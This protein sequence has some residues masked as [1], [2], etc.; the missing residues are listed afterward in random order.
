MMLI[1]ALIALATFSTA[2]TAAL[3]V[4]HQTEKRKRSTYAIKDS[5]MPVLEA[6]DRADAIVKNAAE[7]ARASLLAAEREGLS[8]VEK[9]KQT[10][11][12]L[13]EQYVRGTDKIVDENRK[14]LEEKSMEIAN[15][16][17]TSLKALED[18]GKQ[19]VL[20]KEKEIQ[21]RINQYF[22]TIESSLKGYTD[23][24]KRRTQEVQVPFDQIR[25]ELTQKI[26]GTEKLYNDYIKNVEEKVNASLTTNQNALEETKKAI[27]AKFQESQTGYTE[28]LA[29]S[30]ASLS[31]G[32]EKGRG[33]LES[34][35]NSIEAQDLEAQKSYSDYVSGLKTQVEQ[36][37][38][39]NQKDMDDMREKLRAKISQ[40]E[41][42]YANF[43]KSLED[44]MVLDFNK[45]QQ[46]LDGK[47]DEFFG[48][49]QE[50]LGKFLKELETRTQ[51][52]V[53]QEI[54]SAKKLIEEYKQQRLEVVD[55]N[56]I[57]ILEKTL[58]ITLGKKLTLSDQ[59][60]LIYEA[61]E[62]AK[63]ENFFA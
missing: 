50:M 22:T 44:N 3:L 43:L 25:T 49:A 8:L 35:K 56:L 31:E 2:L 1:N 42:L 34:L 52:Q 45:K 4:I 28:F 7:K 21:E 39:Q 10:Q 48:K 14:R 30:Q 55:E 41:D 59:T 17:S 57:A 5:D 12:Q 29:E 9:Y 36:S 63:K 33:Y 32:L 13:E 54:G 60:Q 11:S 27:E 15:S 51:T 6:Q 20:Q 18:S 58:N 37:F 47:V 62:E 61:L 38:A 24:L 26:T 19:Q 40:T 46:A 53:E 16:F 23:D